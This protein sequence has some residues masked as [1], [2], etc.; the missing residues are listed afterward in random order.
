MR[1]LFV[2]VFLAFSIGLI[3]FFWHTIDT[4]RADKAVQTIAA[5]KTTSRSGLERVYSRAKAK[6]AT[7]RSGELRARTLAE[8]DRLHA[9]RSRAIDQIE[10]LRREEE[11]AQRAREEQAQKTAP[12]QARDE[13]RPPTSEEIQAEVQRRIAEMEKELADVHKTP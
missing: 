7:I 12:P 5:T 13:N 2:L 6:A 1:A 8:I 10:A 4:E 3:V 11:K 9:E